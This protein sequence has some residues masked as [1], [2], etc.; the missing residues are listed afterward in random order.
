MEECRCLSTARSV[1]F[2]LDV[3]AMGQKCFAKSSEQLDFVVGIIVAG[4]QQSEIENMH[5][6]VLVRTVN[7][8]TRVTAPR[9]RRAGAQVQGCS[10]W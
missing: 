2:K 3:K 10:L 6:D 7:A 8:S 5:S 4:V 9:P 1:K